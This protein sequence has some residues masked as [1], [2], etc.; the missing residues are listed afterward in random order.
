[1]LSPESELAR[2][3]GYVPNSEDGT[4]SIIDPRTYRVIQVRRTGRLPQHVTPS[5]E[6]KT[7]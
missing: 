5:Y 1:M 3:L 6:L 4:V 7:L 2:P